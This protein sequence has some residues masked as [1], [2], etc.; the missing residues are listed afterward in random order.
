MIG[1]HKHKNKA[2]RG[3]FTLIEIL[4]VLVIMGFLVAL[5]APKLSGIVDS[6]V[7]VNCDTNQERLRKVLNVYVSQNKALPNGLLN[8]TVISPDA[9]ITN[10]VGAIPTISDGDKTNGAEFLSDEFAERFKPQIH[11]LS[12]DEKAELRGMGVN[13][14]RYVGKTDTDGNATAEIVE[15]QVSGNMN[16]SVV[17]VMMAGVGINKA[18]DTI[19]WAK[20]NKITV[21]GSTVVEDTATQ[22]E[23]TAGT[24]TNANSNGTFTRMDEGKNV[25]RILMGLTNNGEMV[26]SGM[27]DEA[28]ICPG[29]LQNADQFEYGNYVVVLPRLAAT[30]ERLKDNSITNSVSNFNLHAIA[31][32]VDTGKPADGNTIE[33]RTPNGGFKYFTA[34]E[35]HDVTTSCPEGHIWG[36]NADSYAIKID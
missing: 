27:L 17:P 28:G 24:A 29:Q 1:N 16:Q 30:I 19:T 33:G 15:T 23:I 20:G 11:Y 5:V 6:A 2:T 13:G 34:Q 18:G 25:A 36:A 12:E 26:Q 9:N 10:R 21:T 4:V 31:L 35:V 14:F 22:I 8:M 3:A 7:D 32:G